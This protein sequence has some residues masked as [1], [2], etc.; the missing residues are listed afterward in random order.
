MTKQEA[1]RV[2]EVIVTADGSCTWCARD[3]LGKLEKAL[4]GV[5]WGKILQDP[6]TPELDFGHG[7][8]T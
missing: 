1:V 8:D 7:D 4:P 3:L 5:D 2:L 6:T